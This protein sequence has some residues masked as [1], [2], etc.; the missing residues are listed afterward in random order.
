MTNIILSGV[1]TVS[2][3]GCGFNRSMQQIGLSENRPW[4]FEIKIINI[5]RMRI[6]VTHIPDTKV[7]NHLLSVLFKYPISQ[8]L[9]FD[10]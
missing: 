6:G 3:F 2:G 9:G 5:A 4:N 8:F 10:P 1:S 7:Y